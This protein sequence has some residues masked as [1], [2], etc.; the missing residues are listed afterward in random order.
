MEIAFRP[1][2]QRALGNDVARRTEKGRRRIELPSTSKKATARIKIDK[3][4]MIR[5]F[6]SEEG[7]PFATA[8]Q[9]QTYRF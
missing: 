9:C 7:T 5:R 3:V 2:M 6:G 1:A 4:V 8:V